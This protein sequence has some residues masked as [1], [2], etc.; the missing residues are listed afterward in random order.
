[1]ENIRTPYLI[2]RCKVVDKPVNGVKFSENVKLDYMGSAEFEFGAVPRSLRL[3][4]EHSQDYHLVPVRDVT[5]QKGDILYI[6][7]NLPFERVPEYVEIVKK[8]RNTRDIRTKE[9]THFYFNALDEWYN[10]DN[11]RT[12]FW[13]DL[14]NDIMFSFRA[15]MMKVLPGCIA[16]SLEYMN[17]QRNQ[18]A[19]NVAAK[20]FHTR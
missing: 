7:C 14:D 1:M 19:V 8:L 11:E 16:A 2:Q 6:Y 5:N 13:W 9:S 20:C 12:D 15:D 17:E 18:D 10:K 3:I 4:A